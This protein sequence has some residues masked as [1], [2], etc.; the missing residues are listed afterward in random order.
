MPVPTYIFA[1]FIGLFS[2]SSQASSVTDRIVSQLANKHLPALLHQ[3]KNIPWQ[4]GNYNLTVNRAGLVRLNSN[5]HQLELTL[6]VAVKIQA[7]VN[8]P[9]LG[10]N[11]ALNCQAQFNT[12]A[13]VTGQPKFEQEQLQMDIGIDT[14]IPPTALFCDG[15][16]IPIQAVLKEIIATDKLEFEQKLENEINRF[17]QQAGL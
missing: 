15:L 6:P 8:K 5:Q 7:V 13:Q 12:E 3:K 16:R 14:P 9:F 10:A 11:I 2:Y 17:I 4:Y 1:F